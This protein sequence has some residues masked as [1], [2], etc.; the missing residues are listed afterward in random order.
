MVTLGVL[1]HAEERFVI[2]EYYGGVRSLVP[3]GE[4]MD[5]QVSSTTRLFTISQVIKSWITAVNQDAHKLTA[6]IHQAAPSFQ[7][8]ANVSSIQVRSTVSGTLTA[9]HDK[10]AV[11]SLDKPGGESVGGQMGNDKRSNPL[12]PEL[13][14]G[15]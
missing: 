15:E 8:P 12:V 3:L 11:L 14:V 10:N 2:L 7:A 6:S 5:A 4:L 9:V 1:Q 13:A